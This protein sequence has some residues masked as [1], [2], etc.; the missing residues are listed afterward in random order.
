MTVAGP[1]DLS[2]H[3]SGE[4]D[5]PAGQGP[6]TPFVAIIEDRGGHLTGTISEHDLFS[7]A[8]IEAVLAGSRGGASV[9]FTKTYGPGASALYDQ[10]VDYVGRVNADGTVIDGMWSLLDLDG[11]F[12]MRRDLAGEADVAVE[13]EAV[14]A[15]PSDPPIA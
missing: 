12:S 3:W 11:R 8:I 5:Y 2:G 13:R 6:T 14:I 4:F 15:G 10:P 7:G 1:H 9:D